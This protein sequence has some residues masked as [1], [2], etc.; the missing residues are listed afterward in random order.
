MANKTSV[1][2]IHKKNG[3]R[4]KFDVYIGRAVRFTEFTEGSKWA[5]P[6]SSK[7]ANC[8]DMFEMRIRRLIREQPE[9]Y[10][11]R[12]LVGKRLGCWCITTNKIE[13]LICHGQIYLKLIKEFGLE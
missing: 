13:S 7:L 2:D 12:E 3:V 9:K 4:P 6:F 11:L 1:V 5:N 8:L 10:D